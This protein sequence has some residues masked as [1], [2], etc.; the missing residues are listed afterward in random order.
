MVV[1]LGANRNVMEFLR[2]NTLESQV[3]VRMSFS[4][5]F[6][7]QDPHLGVHISFSV[8]LRYNVIKLQACKEIPRRSMSSNYF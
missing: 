8:R 4:L 2:V 6:L 7:R 1:Q 5:P 3:L